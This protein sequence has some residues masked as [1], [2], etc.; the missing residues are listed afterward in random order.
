MPTDPNV[1]ME[2]ARCYKCIPPGLQ[3]SILI[4]LIA[5]WAQH[6]HPI[7]PPFG[8]FQYTPA[9]EVMTWIDGS[10][11]HVGDLAAFYSTPGAFATVTSITVHRLD[12]IIGLNSLLMLTALDVGPTGLGVG[13]NLTVLD[14]S[15]CP[16]LITLNCSQ[17][18]LTTAGLSLTSSLVTLQAG[19]NQL[20]SINVKSF[21]NLTYLDVQH[22]QLGTVFLFN[23][24]VL[25]TL[26]TN[27]NPAVVLDYNP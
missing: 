7:P 11:G 14:V 6:Q 9:T 18:L 17:N 1:L 2:A 3:R 21:V 24:P 25:A 8:P 23:T 27:N 10:G 13:G 20:T 12:T 4:F 16:G 26:W 15:G 5:Q 19:Y 22:N